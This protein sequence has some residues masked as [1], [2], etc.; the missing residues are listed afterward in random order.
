MRVD[1]VAFLHAS[2]VLQ[3]VFLV[4]EGVGACGL[5]TSCDPDVCMPE[6]PGLRG[7]NAGKHE[8]G[9]EDKVYAGRLGF[10]SRLRCRLSVY[11][12]HT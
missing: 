5:H 4:P 12:M 2:E 7:G 10:I 11:C 1:R 6:A 8:S 3:V 9:E